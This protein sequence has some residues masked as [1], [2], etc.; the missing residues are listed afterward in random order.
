MLAKTATK[1]IKPLNPK[2]ADTKYTGLEP[3]WRIQPIEDRSSAL[4]KALYW[5]H[6][7][8]SKKEAK[9]MIIDWLS[10]HDRMNDA[11]K[12]ARV[13][14]SDVTQ[15][16]GWLSRMN[17]RGLELKEQELAKLNFYIQSQI[18]SIVESKHKPTEVEPE[19]AKPNIQDRLREKMIE[20]AADIDA[21]YDTMIEA[22]GKMSADFKPIA[23]LRGKNV[24]PQLTAE[25]VQ[26]WKRHQDELEQALHGRDAQLVEGYSQFGK[27]QLKNLIK[28]CEQVVADCGSYVQIKKVERKPRKVKPVSAE[29]RAAKFK[30]LA[31]FP[32][33]KLKSL[34]ASQLVDKSE[35][36]LYDTKK[37]KLVHLVADPHVG[38]FT[39]KNNSLIGY[40]STES[41]MKTL[42]RPAEQLKD[43]MTSSVPQARKMFKDIKAT[44]V[45]FN[46]RGSEN[47]VLLK[48][49]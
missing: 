11:K 41:V 46:G 39:V 48:S 27:N 14:E 1:P 9:E 5:Y 21:M 18:E 47:L 12:F 13:P 6:Y 37:R 34:P 28:F 36:W 15:T 29:K 26:Q 10:R 22:G 38:A 17:L 3:D 43:I 40:S 25:I 20:A 2:G 42:R 32:E 31:E 33:L 24:A 16:Y 19:A 30:L 23:V 45:K 8:Y 4:T 44:E 49:K 7:H 35:A